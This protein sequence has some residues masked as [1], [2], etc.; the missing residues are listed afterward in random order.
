MKILR[1]MRIGSSGDRWHQR[2]PSAEL[3]SRSLFWVGN[4][5]RWCIRWDLLRFTNIFA[6]IGRHYEIPRISM[7]KAINQWRDI[8]DPSPAEAPLPVD[9]G[10]GFSSFPSTV[11]TI[12]NIW[13]IKTKLCTISSTR[14]SIRITQNAKH[15]WNTGEMYKGN[16]ERTRS[17]KVY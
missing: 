5:S 17:I 3:F 6:Q 13:N 11:Q 10:D 9:L 8:E 12:S 15:K 4:S 14:H 2:Y 16:Q 7:F 1:K